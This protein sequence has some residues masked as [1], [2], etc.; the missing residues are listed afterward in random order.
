MN[1][2]F[3]NAQGFGHS[4]LDTGTQDLLLTREAV[5]ELIGFAISRPT[6]LAWERKGLLKPLRPAGARRK[7]YRQSDVARA[8]GLASENRTGV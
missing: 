4:D 5:Q 7:L 3:D 2:D 6:F 8:F 1:Y